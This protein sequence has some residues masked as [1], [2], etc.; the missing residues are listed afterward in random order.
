MLRYPTYCLFL[1]YI[2]IVFYGNKPDSRPTTHTQRQHSITMDSGTS[3]IFFEIKWFPMNDMYSEIL[4]LGHNKEI[5]SSGWHQ[6]KANFIHMC[7]Y[8]KSVKLT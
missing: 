8:P 6:K 2:M 3:T 1:M 4:E 7:I 5:I